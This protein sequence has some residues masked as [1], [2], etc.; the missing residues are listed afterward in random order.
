M[1]SGTFLTFG[2]GELYAFL[3]S[4]ELVGFN[5]LFRQLAAEGSEKLEAVLSG[6]V[7][8]QEK[9]RRNQWKTDTYRALSSNSWSCSGGFVLWKL[10]SLGNFHKLRLSQA[11]GA[12]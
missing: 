8:S 1:L 6:W 5:S 9:E 3:A 4:D 12:G 2:L 7:D 10:R 11:R